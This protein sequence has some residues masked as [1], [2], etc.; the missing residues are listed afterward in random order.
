MCLVYI[1]QTQLDQ[2]ENDVDGF[3]INNALD[4]QVQK[5]KDLKQAMSAPEITTLLGNSSKAKRGLVNMEEFLSAVGLQ[6]QYRV[7]NTSA[8]PRQFTSDTRLIDFRDL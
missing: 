5:V 7:R 3:L 4:A 8:E 1:Q 2:R 6:D